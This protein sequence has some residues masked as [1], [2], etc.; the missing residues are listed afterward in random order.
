[1]KTIAKITAALGLVL[2]LPT[3]VSAEEYE[4]YVRVGDRCYINVG[5]TYGN[6]IEIPCPNDVSEY[7]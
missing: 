7:P 4:G 5:I 6:W 2:A 1:M 3:A